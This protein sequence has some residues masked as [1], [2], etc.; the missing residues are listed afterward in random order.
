[1]CSKTERAQADLPPELI[2]RIID[3]LHDEPKILVACSLV[4]RSWTATCRYHQF[5]TVALIDPDNCAKYDRLIKISPAM[6]QCVRSVSIDG[7]GTYSA[8][9]ISECASFTSLQ[10]IT[11]RGVITPPWRSEGAAISSV[12]HN[13]TSFTLNLTVVHRHDVWPII[14]MFPNL[15]SL[16]YV[17]AR[18]VPASQPLQSS[19]PGHTP[20]ISTISITTASWGVLEDLADPPYPLIFLST[21]NIRDTYPVQG[22]GLQALAQA[23][24]GRISRL[25]LH[26]L[27]R[28]PQCMSLG[29]SQPPPFC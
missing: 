8:R 5:S 7:D 17:G 18:S 12:A 13:I 16:K 24:G 20:P 1:M 11:M 3:F 26:T 28:S 23:Y 29:H 21:L 27:A 6:V 4:A 22:R 15:V 10:H 14:R 2:D 19:F 9:W 25:R